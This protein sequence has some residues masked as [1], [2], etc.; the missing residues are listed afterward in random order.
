MTIDWMETRDGHRWRNYTAYRDADGFLR[1]DHGGHV[2]GER[3]ANW[4][5]METRVREHNSRE[6]YA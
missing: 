6:V 3:F 5:E 2:W 1:V 4:R